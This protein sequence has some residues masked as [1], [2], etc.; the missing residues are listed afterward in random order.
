MNEADNAG[1]ERSGSVEVIT[2]PKPWGHETIWAHTDRYVGKILH[3]NAGHSLSVQYHNRKDETVHLLNGELIY[4][5]KLGQEL[6]DMR[7]TRGQSFRI[8][9]GTVHQME[10][11]TDCDILEASTA[12]LEDVVRLQDRYGREGTSAP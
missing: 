3:I 12:E 7:L 11:I 6:E 1:G 2:V 5:V 10:A 8:T 9:P 4:R